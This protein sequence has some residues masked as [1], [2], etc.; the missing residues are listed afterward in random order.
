MAAPAIPHGKIGAPQVVNRV[1][2]SFKNFHP[3]ASGITFNA[4]TLTATNAVNTNA[5]RLS[6]NGVDVSAALAISGP[7]TNASVAYHG[8]ASNT[9]Y[10]AQVVLRDAL[11]RSTTNA[12]TFDTFSDAYVAS[13]AV[14]V[15]EAEDYDFNGGSFIDNPPASGYYDYD[16]SLDTGTVVNNGVGYVDQTGINAPQSSPADFFS[17]DTSVHFGD[18]QYRHADS[19]GTQQGNF[20]DFIYADESVSGGIAYGQTYDTQRSKYYNLNPTLQEYIVERTQGGEWLNYTR[21]FNGTSY[22]AYLR[23]GAGLAQPVRLDQILAGPQ[24]NLLGTFNVPATFFVHNYAYAP[25]VAAD[26][27]LAEVALSGTNT[28]RLTL[29]SP[30]NDATQYGLAMNYVVFVPAAPRLYSSA[31]VQGTYTSELNVLLDSA[32][33]QFTVPQGGATRFYRIGWTGQVRITG[34]ALSGGNV[35]LSYQ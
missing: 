33:K 34:A 29:N 17:Y 20:G 14:K 26:G 21:I 8:L 7:Q 10:N 35:V 11:G 23:A 27:S 18:A 30:Q 12:W 9:V 31:T 32:T 5:I 22:N 25:L 1:P 24:T 19:V 2:P 16:G 4:T 13:A 3:A 15:I 6:L 28:V